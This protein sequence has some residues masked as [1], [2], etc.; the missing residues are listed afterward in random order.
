MI[1]VNLK[2]ERDIQFLPHLCTHI[3]SFRHN[4][5]FFQSQLNKNYFKDFKY[6][7]FSQQTVT[8]FPVD[9][10][11]EALGASKIKF[12]SYFTDCDAI[13]ND[14][15]IFQICYHDIK[16]L[17]LELQLEM[18]DLQWSDIFAVSVFHFHSLISCKFFLKLFICA[19]KQ[20]PKL[21]TDKIFKDPI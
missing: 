13:A 11:I 2:L 12:E 16:T 10:W 17:A 14:I 20:S 15:K 1:Q 18:I 8:P 19:K 4:N 6:Q 21:N 3:E 7:T 5:V 9:F